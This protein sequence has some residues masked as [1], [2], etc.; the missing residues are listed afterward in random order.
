MKLEETSLETLVNHIADDNKDRILKAR[1]KG[2]D[3]SS[4]YFVLH[5]PFERQEEPKYYF[6]FYNE[7]FLLAPF[8]VIETKSITEAMLHL[9]Y[10]FMLDNCDAE[11][12]APSDYQERLREM[13]AY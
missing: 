10:R 1:F 13:T 8:E 11:H 3:I 6:V 12:A 4:L 5:T 7:D 2:R 9:S